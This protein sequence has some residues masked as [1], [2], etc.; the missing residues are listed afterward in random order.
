[1]AGVGLVPV[2]MRQHCWHACRRPNP[3]STH[4]E[5][6]FFPAESNFPTPRVKGWTGGTRAGVRRN[7]EDVSEGKQ[8]QAVLKPTDVLTRPTVCVECVSCQ[9]R[10][11]RRR[12]RVV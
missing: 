5:S 11:R 4:D 12:R 10:R 8:Q 9:W 2:Q 1:M 3:D 7:N 6:T